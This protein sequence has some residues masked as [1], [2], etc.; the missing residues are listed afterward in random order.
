MVTSFGTIAIS[1]FIYLQS[2][3]YNMRSMPKLQGKMNFRNE[4]TMILEVLA[5]MK[6]SAEIPFSQI[7]QPQPDDKQSKTVSVK[8]TGHWA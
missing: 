5:S 2:G 1:A 8:S 6:S 4:S 7:L 3:M